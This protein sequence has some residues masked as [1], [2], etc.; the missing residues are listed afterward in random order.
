LDLNEITCVELLVAAVERGSPP[1]DCAR[2]AAGIYLKERQSAVEALRRLLQ[3]KSSPD[4]WAPAGGSFLAKEIEDYVDDLLRGTAAAAGGT[5]LVGRLLDI[6]RKP[7]PGSPEISRNGGTGVGAG[8]TVQITPGGAVQTPGGGAAGTPGLQLATVAAAVTTDKLA[9]LEALE[10]VVDDRGR[11]CRRA[12]W[13]AHERRLVAECLF[14]AVV[15]SGAGR[16][17]LSASDARAI[18]EL[19]VD[20]AAPILASAAADARVKQISNANLVFGGSNGIGNGGGGGG[21][22]GGGSY[23]GVGAGSGASYWSAGASSALPGQSAAAAGDPGGESNAEDLPAAYVILFATIAA[24]TPDAPGAGGAA[25]HAAVVDAVGPLLAAAS[26]TATATA[27]AAAL[28]AQ[29]PERDPLR[30]GAFGSGGGGG[31]F[32]TPGVAAA[33]TGIGGIP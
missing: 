21:G 33:R 25:A 20:V 9:A 22:A 13:F 10:M 8:Y 26:A 3:A 32:A 17:A 12:D 11:P 2:A 27:A 1:D 14:H 30:G 6:L 28:G 24:L 29:S 19:M 15:A 23:T 7:A 31:G 18:V 5:T 4:I 16:S